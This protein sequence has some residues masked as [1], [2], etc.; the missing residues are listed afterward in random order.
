MNWRMIVAAFAAAVLVGP[1]QTQEDRSSG[2]YMLPLCKTWLRMGSRDLDVIKN[3]IRACDAKSGGIPIYFMQ[4]GM[5]AGV[6]IGISAMLEPMACVPNEVTNEQLVRVVVTSI[7]KYP[8][9]RHEN[10]SALAGAAMV[11]EWPCH[12]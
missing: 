10:F 6:V 11:T 9:T 1:A 2:N 12:R 8:A 7:E 4:A 5:C 3:E